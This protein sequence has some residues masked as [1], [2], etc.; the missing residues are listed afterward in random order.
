MVEKL[1][2]NNG[3]NFANAISL[4]S[5]IRKGIISCW[6]LIQAKQSERAV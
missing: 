5:S 2:L 1:L 6:T 4:N 3:Q